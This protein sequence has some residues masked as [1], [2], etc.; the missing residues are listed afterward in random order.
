LRDAA[1]LPPEQTEG[2]ASALADAFQKQVATKNDLALVEK[3][4]TIKVGG[5][6]MVAIGILTVIIKDLP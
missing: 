3:H 1:N 4:L 6:L 2:F 5:M